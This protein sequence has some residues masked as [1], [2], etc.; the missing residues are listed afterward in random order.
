MKVENETGL[1]RDPVSKVVIN[2]DDI[3]YNKYLQNRQR[4]INAQHQVEKNTTDINDIKNEVSEI[5]SML[6]TILA[7][8]KK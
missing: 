6:V 2:K 5:K 3:S 8:I 7:N 1:Y 4:L